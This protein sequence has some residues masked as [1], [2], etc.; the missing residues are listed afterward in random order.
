MLHFLVKSRSQQARDFRQQ[1]TE[2]HLS[3]APMRLAK[4]FPVMSSIK[5][6]IPIYFIGKVHYNQD[7]YNKF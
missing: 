6:L 7:N 2:I 5:S 4:L 1:K 3:S